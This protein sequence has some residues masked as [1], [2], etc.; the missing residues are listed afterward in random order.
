[1]PKLVSRNENTLVKINN[2]Y[3]KRLN[4]IISCLNILVSR[5]PCAVI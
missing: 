5:N 1:M 4:Y 3:F 2:Y